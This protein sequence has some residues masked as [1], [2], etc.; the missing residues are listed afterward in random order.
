MSCTLPRVLHRSLATVAFQNVKR[1]LPDPMQDLKKATDADTT[2]EKI[3][4]GAGVYR[5]EQGQ[6]HE[7]ATIRKAKQRLDNMNVGHDYNP[8]TGIPSFTQKAASLIFGDQR[9]ALKDRRIAT[10]QTIGGTGANRIGAAFLRR[11]LYD[12]DDN[13]PTAYLGEPA[14]GNYRPLFENAGFRVISYEHSARGDTRPNFEAILSSVERAPRGS[15][16]I[17]QASCHNPTGLEYSAEQWRVLADKFLHYGHF[18]FF[19][20]AYIG[21]G[22]GQSDAL[23]SD[24][25]ALRHFADRKVDMLVCQSFSKI[26]G[27]YSERVGALHIVCQ[28]PEIAE[29][30]FDQLRAQTRWEVSSA[31]AYGARLV[32]II[33]GDPQLT[34]E[35][36][37]ELHAAAARVSNNRSTL[38]QLLS[39]GSNEP[40]LWDHIAKERGL[41]S[42]LRLDKPQ[43]DVLARKHHVYLPPNGRINVAG[44]TKA[45]TQSAATAIQAVLA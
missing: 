39:S 45:N 20:A 25:W 19:D 17:L 28:S 34:E 18:A 38:H 6:Y 43:I 4:I 42:F 11:N 27:L 24:A 33:L 10:V 41:F 37:A 23:D 3:D 44:L 9:S 36:K 21:F 1:G 22:S 40:G 12:S 5:N 2:V 32:D 14:W 13:I 30:V 16:F 8:T 29:N 35:W 7:F 31:P 15:I 26:F